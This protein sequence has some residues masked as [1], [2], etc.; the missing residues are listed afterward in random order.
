MDMKNLNNEK[1]NEIVTKDIPIFH[2]DE[3]W[4]KSNSL[5]LMYLINIIQEQNTAIK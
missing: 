4:K 2:E 3:Q 5:F 1:E